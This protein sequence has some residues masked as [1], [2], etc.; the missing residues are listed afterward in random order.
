MPLI[1][2]GGGYGV[3]VDGE[4]KKRTYVKVR[5]FQ[6]GAGYGAKGLTTVVV[7]HTGKMMKK[8]RTGT[9]RLGASAGASAGDKGGCGGTGGG[10]DFTPYVFTDRGVS[11]TAT[12][13]ILRVTSYSSLNKK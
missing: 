6:L 9:W 4:T 10:E 1:G 2:A 7:F 8:V 13:N 3:V 11:A 12:F 5:E